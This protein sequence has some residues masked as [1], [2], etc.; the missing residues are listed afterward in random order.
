MS[1]RTG[2]IAA[3]FYVVGGVLLLSGCTSTECSSVLFLDAVVVHFA[4]TAVSDDLTTMRAC[5]AD[6]CAERPVDSTT[7]DRSIPIPMGARDVTV[8]VAGLTRTG[9]QLFAGSATVT[10]VVSQ[11]DGPGCQS[12][13]LAKV[14]LTGSRLSPS[15]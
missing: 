11:P 3:T 10:P 4:S 14:T 13:H 8:T 6:T 2:R 12:A 7:A 5:I 15:G 1:T 9:Q